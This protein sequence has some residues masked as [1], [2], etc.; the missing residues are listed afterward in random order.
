MIKEVLKLLRETKSEAEIVKLAKGK[1]KYPET[2]K[3]LWKRL[4]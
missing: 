2:F 1:N 3:E 4:R